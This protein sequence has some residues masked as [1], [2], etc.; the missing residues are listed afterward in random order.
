MNS[1]NLVNLTLASFTVSFPFELSTNIIIL[2]LVSSYLKL[3]SGIETVSIVVPMPKRPHFY[4]VF[5]TDLFSIFFLLSIF[6]L[7]NKRKLKLK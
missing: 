6:G 2:K 7:E 4:K 3:L 5:E 1:T